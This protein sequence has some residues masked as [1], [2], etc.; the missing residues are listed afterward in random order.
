[1]KKILLL[2]SSIGLVACSDGSFFNGTGESVNFCG[3]VIPNGEC[4]EFSDSFFGLGGDFPCKIT[5]EGGG[6]LE[7]LS[8]DDE[9]EVGHWV[10][11]KVTEYKV[12]NTGKT[13]KKEEQSECPST[14]EHGCKE[15][16]VTCKEAPQA[17]E[18]ECPATCEHGCKGDGATCKE[19]PQAQEPECPATCEHGCKGD[20]A[21]CKEAPA[22]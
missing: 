20:G 11:S 9:Y 17:Q 10:A 7:G 6:A 5:K 22:S 13:C 15:D 8:E 16:G 19:A 14:C 12:E 2:L 21:T 4:K 3:Q 18:P 1:M